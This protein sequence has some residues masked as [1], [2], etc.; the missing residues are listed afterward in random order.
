MVDCASGNVSVEPIWPNWIGKDCSD[1]TA[2]NTRVGTHALP[3]QVRYHNGHHGYLLGASVY[4]ASGKTPTRFWPRVCYRCGHT[5]HSWLLPDYL[6]TLSGNTS[7]RN[8]E[9]VTKNLFHLDHTCRI[10][11]HWHW[12]QPDPEH[13]SYW[14]CLHRGVIAGPGVCSFL[15]RHHR[16]FENIS[17]WYS[18][19]AYRISRKCFFPKM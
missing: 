16:P 14:H 8:C 12:I 17:R 15:N 9:S 7:I 11:Q 4:F 5:S 10:D 1:Y 13:A 3:C 19:L 18:L 6:W 2:Q